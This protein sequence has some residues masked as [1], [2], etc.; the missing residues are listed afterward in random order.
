MDPGFL[1]WSRFERPLYSLRR[2]VLSCSNKG[3]RPSF[4]KTHL[5]HKGVFGDTDMSTTDKTMGSP[6]LKSSGD[7]GDVSCIEAPKAADGTRSEY[8]EY[9]ELKREFQGDRL[10]KLIRKV[11]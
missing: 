2:S 5:N 6:S 4:V 9:L 11:E 10:K 3:S 8:E 7:V 1:R